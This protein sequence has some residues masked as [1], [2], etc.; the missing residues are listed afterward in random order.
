MSRRTTVKNPLFILFCQK[1]NIWMANE[2][3]LFPQNS[4]TCSPCDLRTLGIGQLN[5]KL[6]ILHYLGK[7]Q[8][9][10]LC[11]CKNINLSTIKPPLGMISSLKHKLLEKTCYNLK[12]KNLLFQDYSL[13]Y[14]TGGSTIF[15]LIFNGPRVGVWYNHYLL[16]QSFLWFVAYFKYA[17]LFKLD[18]LGP[19]D[20]RPST[21]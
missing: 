4:L 6:W 12:T 9:V 15:H 17:K 7:Y 11:K 1:V 16:E 10:K 21:D 3:S 2:S 19:V 18:G 8:T 13:S 14:G 5:S 20:N